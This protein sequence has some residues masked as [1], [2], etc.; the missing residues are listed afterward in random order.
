[1]M[2]KKT[3]FETVIADVFSFGQ[4]IKNTSLN[5]SE[6]NP[7]LLLQQEALLSKTPNIKLKEPTQKLEFN[8]EK[9]GQACCISVPKVHQILRLFTR[10]IVSYKS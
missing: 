8:T 4:F 7:C 2:F 3:N 10:S 1:M 5:Q 9:V 6:F